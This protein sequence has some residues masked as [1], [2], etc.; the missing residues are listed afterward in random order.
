M[1]YSLQLHHIPAIVYMS[2]KRVSP[3]TQ[4]WFFFPIPRDQLIIYAKGCRYFRL[5]WL[6]GVESSF[7]KHFDSIYAYIYCQKT[8]DVYLSLLR[9]HE[10]CFSYLSNPHLI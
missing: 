10:H 4:V 7:T 9:I 2:E 6:D 5:L 1:Q 3:F 8:H